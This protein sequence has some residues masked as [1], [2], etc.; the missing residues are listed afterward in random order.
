MGL[1]AAQLTGHET[2]EEILT[3]ALQY[4]KDHDNLAAATSLIEGLLADGL[5]AEQRQELEKWDKKIDAAIKLSAFAPQAKENLDNQVK[6]ATGGNLD[7]EKVDVLLHKV[8]GK[9]I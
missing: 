8:L 4:T 5:S 7:I 6:E 2:T 3:I 1:I 9:A